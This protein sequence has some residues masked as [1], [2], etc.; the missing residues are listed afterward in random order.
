MS[1]STF[2][3][4]GNYIDGQWVLPSANL[5]IRSINP[6]DSSQIV[7]S[8]PTR[9]EDA[10]AAARAAHGAA[11]AWAALTPEARLAA[12]DRFAASL[13]NRVDGLADAITLEMGK[14][15]SEAGIEARS[16]LARVQLVRNQQVPRVS[17]WTAPGV[18]GECRYRPLGVIGVIGP[19]NFPLHLIH[20]HVIPALAT[21][22]AVVIKPSERTPLAAQRYVEAWHE[23]GLP[24]VLQL[25]QG[26]GDVGRALC[27]APELGGLAFTGSWP[28]GHAIE[29]SLIE[30]PD[31]LV[32]LEMGGQNMALID[33][34]ADLDQALEGAL[35]GGFL[36]TGQ[37]CTC[38]SRVLV[39]RDLAQPFMERLV[40]ATS[41]LTW[42]DP[43]TD[44]FMGPLASVADRDHVDALCA[45][46][47][48]A[49][50]EVLLAP[51]RR[52]GGAW[53]GPSIHR[54]APD[55]DSD[56]TRHE[57]FG[58]DLA[59]TIVDDLDE[60]L[61]VASRSDY[62]LSA[63][64]FT[65]S[66]ASFE[67]AFQGLRV[68]CLNWNRSTNRASGAFPFGGLGRSGNYRPAGG[69]AVRYTTY[70]VQMQWN[71]LGK[72][73]DQP[74]V[75]RAL[76]G[77]PGSLAQAAPDLLDGLERLHRL[78]EACEPYA[79]YPV[80]DS[81]GAASLDVSSLGEPVR[82]AL[83]DALAALGCAV[84]VDTATWSLPDTL[85]PTA[86]GDA[87]Y[88]VRAADP[89]RFLGRRPEGSLVPEGDSLS[90]P[91]S[92]AYRRRLLEGDFMPDDKKPPVLDLHRSSGPYLASVDDDPLVLFDA[93]AQI[94]TQ[95]G[96]LN[97]PEIL[98]ALH[99]GAFGES[100]LMAAPGQ[101]SD[102]TALREMATLL[103]GAT[104][105][106]L[107]YV[108]FGC[109]GAQAN[110][111]ALRV[112]SRLRPG[113]KRVISFQGA[114]H[115]RTMLALHNTWNP[116]KRERF[117]LDGYGACWIDWPAWGHDQPQP[118]QWEMA[119]WDEALGSAAR[120]TPTGAD[121]L[122]TT[123]WE[124]L[125]AVEQAMED[126]GALALLVEPMQAE[127]GE[128]HATSRFVSRLRALATAYGVPF[129]VDEVQT[130]FGLGGPFFW[131]TL[132]QLSTPPDVV[133]VAKKA[134]V[135]AILSQTPIGDTD[136]TYVASVVRGLVQA[137]IIASGDAGAC[138]AR[139]LPKL[140][141][142]QAAHPDRVGHPRATGYSFG[143]DLPSK[144]AVGHIIGQR[145]WRGYMLYGAGERA[146][147]FRLHPHISEDT[148]DALFT[149]LDAS[150]RLLGTGEPPHWQTVAPPDQA[151]S[152]PPTQRELPT[153]IRFETVDAHSWQAV[154]GQVA[155]LQALCYEPARR[156][157]MALFGAM[158]EDSGAVFLVAV[159]GRAPLGEAPL[160]GTAFALP[161]EFE[162]ALDGPAQDPMLGRGNTVYSADV[163]VHPDHR[164]RGLG[165]ALKEAQVRAAML[166][167]RPDGSPR[168]AFMTGRNRVGETPGIQAINERFGAWQVS[169]HTGQYGEADGAALY[170]RI[171][172]GAPRLP[173]VPEPAGPAL[174]SLDLASGLSAAFGDSARL[175]AGYGELARG[176]RSGALNGGLANKVSLCNFITP[177]VVR[178]SEW[179]RAIAP[180]ELAHLVT[181]NGRAETVDKGLRA[182]K[183]HRGEGAVAIAVGPV[184]GGESTAASRSL[185]FSGDHEENHFGWPT[186]ADPCEDMDRALSDAREAIENAGAE[187]TLAM[188]IEPVYSLTGRA[189]P[190][191]FWARL[192]ALADETGVPLVT[193]ENTSAAYR[194]GRG[195]FRSSS[196]PIAVD[197]MW[198]Y[199]GGQTG[200]IFLSDEL[201]V[202]DKLTLISTWD[203]DEVSMTRMLWESRLAR[204][205]P[206][207]ER[208]A[209]LRRIA[210]GL[211]EVDGEGL[212]LS[213]RTPDDDATAGM[214]L[215]H[216]IRVGRA[217]D[218][219]L[220]LSP[221]LDIS[222]A[223][224]SRLAEAAAIVRHD[225]TARAS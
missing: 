184:W 127:G 193:L 77:A 181:S 219:A 62:G 33:H 114:F 78:E 217:Q 105:G 89:A 108:A 137:S 67:R 166:L 93:A 53:R 91:R 206:I 203:G 212:Y 68:G 75:Q 113:K 148:L 112:A 63:S 198:W 57:V 102:H 37:R 120:P 165:V 41:K 2:E 125:I 99:T 177:N 17:T 153:D 42:G 157:D 180:A 54:I 141:A 161:L 36:T 174:P 135:G 150:L 204:R 134:Q 3:P 163:T 66:R 79:L 183:F 117:E 187:R 126:D 51:E 94:A 48:E 28:T 61:S 23:A 59:V 80:I 202:P 104:E 8:A 216:G 155:A 11:P 152:W 34:D 215:D 139:V 52:E 194:S 110:E 27:S 107:P 191:A 132:F 76:G 154:K 100:P 72:L 111:M 4:K 176:L 56:Y 207:G 129:I 55:H 69:D 221:P 21:G 156:D 32:A 116:A 9:A 83:S 119:G 49:G 222:E 39:H 44:V 124:S 20:A 96:G 103:R 142:L 224:L 43:N 170:Y 14:V 118:T 188:V 12:L 173:A 208:G 97:P 85:D 223:E 197:A 175:S 65:A 10:L 214:L 123:E 185:S 164:G 169:V 16:L 146:L 205:L 131:H 87:L 47:V 84:S 19:F 210:E 73:E 60:A 58:P 178:A 109:S 74:H 26:A 220:L 70:P 195:A 199:P 13:A 86:L 64:V 179:L 88:S 71:D 1:A 29:K 31:V 151:R 213:V 196:L 200:F 46:G 201:Y 6:A 82:E 144:E 5:T 81:G 159:Q 98:E 143:F 115:G 182:I 7:L 136:E 15:R 92:E 171:P 128:R 30:R 122:L 121:A 38:T 172:L 189:V 158:L 147:R 168:Y 133:T 45:A 160:L 25:V 18:D 149:R 101:P 95:A 192:R 106:A 225:V 50:A 90:L 24:P 140:Q 40:E 22:N 138:E 218:G 190:E 130:G 186:T 35:L 145:L 209:R 211:G 162:A 167:E